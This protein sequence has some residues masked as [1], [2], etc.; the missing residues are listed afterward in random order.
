MGA[1]HIQGVHLFEVLLDVGFSQF[2]SGDADV[3]GGL[4]YLVVNISKVLN[5]CY[6]EA[7]EFE[8]SSYHIEH[9]G[10][11]G[12]SDVRR[13]IGSDAAHIH[14]NL[15][16]RSGELLLLAREGV[17][18]FHAIRSMVA[19][20]KLPIPSP[21]PMKPKLSVVVALTLTLSIVNPNAW[22]SDCLMLPI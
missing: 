5:V 9:N 1:L 17:V 8:V 13:G 16:V 15:V 22:A 6:L 18:E 7:L 12:V 14:P 4:D 21:C 10:H 11:H 2:L 20:A 3:V 19:I